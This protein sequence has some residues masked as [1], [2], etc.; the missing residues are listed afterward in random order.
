MSSMC[1]CIVTVFWLIHFVNAEVRVSGIFNDSMVLQIPYPAKGVPVTNIFG[2]ALLNEN[3]LIKGSPGFPGPFKLAPTCTNGE[4]CEY[5]NWSIPIVP[6]ENDPYFPGP[7]SVSISSVDNQTNTVVN[8]I[9]F[10][11]VYFGEVFLCSGTESKQMY[12][13][14][15]QHST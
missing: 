9:T 5:G 2:T 4:E 6:N 11:D 14:L 7:Y 8:S 15:N 13:T 10:N 12:Q 1:S 3:V